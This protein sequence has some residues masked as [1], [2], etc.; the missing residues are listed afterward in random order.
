[1]GEPQLSVGF[2]FR[3]IKSMNKGTYS[4]RRMIMAAAHSKSAKKPVGKMVIFGICSTIIYGALLSYQGLITS[5]FTRGA[6]YAAMPIAGAFLLSYVHGHFTSYFWS[7]LGIEANQ[8]S[9]RPRTEVG[10]TDMRERPQP[11]PRLRA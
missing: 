6:F 11:Q 8:R 10:R 1:M 7:V 2:G 5:Y 3:I 9:L 4:V